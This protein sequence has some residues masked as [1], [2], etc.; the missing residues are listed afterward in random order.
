MRQPGEGQQN[1]GPR[2]EHKVYRVSNRIKAQVP[3]DRGYP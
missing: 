1:F 3:D 2:L